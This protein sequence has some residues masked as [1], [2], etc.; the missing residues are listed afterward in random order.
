MEYTFKEIMVVAAARKIKNYDIVFCGTGISILA[1]MAAK[2]INAPKSIIFFETG[3]VDSSLEELPL[4]VSDPRVMHNASSYCSLAETFAFMQNHNTGKNI[5]G[6]IGAAQID[7]YGNLNSTCIGDYKKPSVRLPGSGGAC[8]VASFVGRTIIFM[9]LEKK[10]FVETVDYITSPGW[11]PAVAGDNQE[12][13]FATGPTSVVTDMCTMGFDENTKE[14]YLDTIY[15][16]IDPLEII[17]N[18]GFYIDISR[19]KEIK[20]PLK[21]ELDALRDKCDPE[22]LIL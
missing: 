2:Q 18:I 12:D 13:L 4:A 14:M 1:A 10:K 3:A 8:D 9:K 20:P 15:P 7:R 21:E 6:I 11:T 5:I 16:G 17:N 22:R 19:A